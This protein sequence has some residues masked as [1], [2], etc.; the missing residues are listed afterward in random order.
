MSFDR[1]APHYRWIE[2]LFAGDRLQRC[3]VALLDAIPA[4]RKVLVFGEGNGRFLVELLRR[5]P[6]ARVTVVEASE[7]MIDLARSRLR[8]EGLDSASV[9][10]VQ[11][12]SLSW[13][14]PASAFDLIVTC[15]FLDCFREDQLQLLIPR[16]AS[17]ADGDAR[18]LVSDFQIATSG[19]QR[20]LSRFIVG[21][22]YLFFRMMTRLPG[23]ELVDPAPLLHAAGFTCERRVEQDHS[24]LYSA[25]WRR[26]EIASQAR[27]IT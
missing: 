16:I 26:A 13:E 25:V 17:A 8:R 23:R 15:F 9:T 5:F 22:L 2:A 14:P 4:P 24:L 20:V 7:V 11:V 3:R 19:L 6:N 27:R 18:W 1:L 12:D 10:F 21:M